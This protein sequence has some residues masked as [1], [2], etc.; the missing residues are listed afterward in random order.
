MMTLEEAVQDFLAQKHIAVAGVSR[1][2]AEAANH[3]YKKLRGAGYLVSATNP[4][5]NEV[6]GDPCY[7]DLKSIPTQIDGVM[8]ATHPDAAVDIVHQCAELGINRVWFHRSFGE[9]SVNETAVA[10][11]RE[12][13]MTVIAGGCPMMFCKPV[14]FAHKCMR[15]VLKA[16]G[17]LPQEI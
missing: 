6:E 3:V 17:K 11:C 8:I 12:H 13:Q 14:D 1:H 2:G 5:A 16:T 4:H 10:F 7:P 15:W 9:G